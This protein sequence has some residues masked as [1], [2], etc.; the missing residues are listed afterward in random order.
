MNMSAELDRTVRYLLTCSLFK[1]PVDSSSY[2]ASSDGA[3]S[4]MEI[5]RGW[6]TRRY[7][8]YDLGVCLKASTQ[9]GAKI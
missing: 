8:Y 9:I 2:A 1:E 7:L 6:L 5:C 4:G 3:G